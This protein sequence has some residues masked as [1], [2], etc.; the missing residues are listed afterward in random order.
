MNCV[1]CEAELPTPLDTF[2]DRDAS[3]CQSCWLEPGPASGWGGLEIFTHVP[4]E[5]GSGWALRKG[6]DFDWF[7]GDA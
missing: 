6:P 3:L 2:G 5:D 4:L 1:I 7:F